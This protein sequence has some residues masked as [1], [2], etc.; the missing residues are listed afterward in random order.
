MNNVSLKTIDSYEYSNL[1]FDMLVDNIGDLSLSYFK[2]LSTEQNIDIL[3]FIA[4]MNDL[5]YGNDTDTIE[6]IKGAL[7]WIRLIKQNG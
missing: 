5:P 1:L 4:R 6:E 7:R 3:E 2:A